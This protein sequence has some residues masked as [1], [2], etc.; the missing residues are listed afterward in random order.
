M[1]NAMFSY[2]T[3]VLARSKGEIDAR[4]DDGRLL[5]N[6][7]LPILLSVFK[8]YDEASMSEVELHLLALICL[9]LKD[10]PSRLS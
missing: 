3:S 5:R 10:E 1:Y 7:V 2:L 8:H 4:I 6:A 9:V